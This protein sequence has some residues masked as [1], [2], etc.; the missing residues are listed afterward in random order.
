MARV[1]V[2][3]S[4]CPL[5]F[6][7]IPTAGRDFCG[8]CKRRVHNLDGMSDAQRV[9]FFANCSGEVCVSYSIRRSGALAG[10]LGVA[11]SVAALASS[12]PAAAAETEPSASAPQ[13]VVT[14]PTCD[15]NARAQTL[16]TIVL[17]GGTSKAEHVQWVDESEL[18]KTAPPTIGDVG[19][20]EWLP[21]PAELK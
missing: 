7:S 14:G 1:P 12:S 19:T 16:D 6:A 4:P 9:A 20:A 5:R 15:P 10:V 11:A 13:P 21:T 8:Q 18:A 3:T 2:I 17:T